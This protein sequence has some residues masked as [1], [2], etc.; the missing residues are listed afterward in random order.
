MYNVLCDPNKGNLNRILFSVWMLISLSEWMMTNCVSSK[1]F[2]WIEIL[3]IKSTL[4]SLKI[5]YDFS[6]ENILI[7]LYL[8]YYHI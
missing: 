1:L 4:K 7:R 2:C 3:E 8:W 6:D 5:D